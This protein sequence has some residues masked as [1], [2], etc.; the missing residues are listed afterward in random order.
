MFL[1]QGGRLVFRKSATNL[2]EHPEAFKRVLERNE[3]RKIDVHR[4][5]RLRPI[6]ESQRSAQGILLPALLQGHP[7]PAALGGET[8]SIVTLT[9]F[10]GRTRIM[11]SAA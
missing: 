7:R 3:K 6:T 11:T 10:S 4:G 2:S 9:S 1:K 8:E 5:S